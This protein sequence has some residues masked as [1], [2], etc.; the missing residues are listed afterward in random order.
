MLDWNFSLTC[1]TV[2]ACVWGGCSSSLIVLHNM[3]NSG[4]RR[5]KKEVWAKWQ[6]RWA[7]FME[8]RHLCKASEGR[9]EQHAKFVCSKGGWR[10]ADSFQSSLFQVWE[11]LTPCVWWGMVITASW[12]FPALCSFPSASLL[13]FFYVFPCTR[14]NWCFDCQKLS[15]C[16]LKTHSSTPPWRPFGCW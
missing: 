5:V 10:A 15:G 4:C 13:Y 1:F 14:K 8:N 16:L 2:R 9:V 7:L 3:S 12:C 11:C 6:Q